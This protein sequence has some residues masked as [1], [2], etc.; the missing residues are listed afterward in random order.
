VRILF[1]RHAQAELREAALYYE[2]QA[3]GL[4]AT[5]VL[6]VTAALERLAEFP[7]A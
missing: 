7:T 3:P 4:G 5:F 2:S 6:E 1:L